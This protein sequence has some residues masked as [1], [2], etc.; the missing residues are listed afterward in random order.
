MKINLLGGDDEARSS[1]ASS[2]RRLNLYSELTDPKQGEPGSLTH[3]P[4]PGLKL[5]AQS[6]NGEN[7]RGLYRASNGDLYAAAGFEI[8]Y[9]DPSWT[10]NPIG[11]MNQTPQ[12]NPVKMIDNGVSLIIC[13]GTATNG[14]AVNM[15]SRSGLKPLYD[16]NA[17]DAETDSST[18][19]LGSTFVDFS[20]GY[21]IANYIG[22]PTFYISNS[23]DT[24]FDPLQFSGKT[25]YPDD[26][27]GAIVQHRV[28]WLIGQLTTEVW[29][30][31]GGGS[32]SGNNFPFEIMPGVAID[33]GCAAPYSIAKGDT[34]I[35]WLGQNQN[36]QVQVLRGTGYAVQRISTH[37][38]ETIFSRYTVSD[39]IAYF[40]TQGGHSFY[41]MSFPTSDATWA[42]D[43][44]TGHWHQRACIDSDGK[45]HRHRA[46]MHAFAYGINVV[47]DW[48][49][50][51][52][53]AFDPKIFNDNGQPIKRVLGFPRQID[54][55]NDHRVV[56]KN[57]VAEVDVGAG[58]APDL[59]P[60]MTLKWSDDKGKTFGNGMLMSIG[61]IGR[62]N[63]F[64]KWNRLGL[65]RNRTF[66]LE[67]NTDSFIALQGGFVE[68]EKSRA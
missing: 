60:T 3:Y 23:E 5:L 27:V 17:S 36:G 14:Y 48:A 42:Y 18:G 61:A 50:N 49:S 1:L 32:I 52:I 54:S 51:A 33:W 31:S 64:V 10:F 29:Y 68:I 6:P 45:E 58:F 12:R 25:A 56:F 24:I 65:A 44:A 40:Y 16:P 62:Y 34:S 15:A 47:N 37:A 21:L 38:M 30:N 67:W 22:T 35:F 20:D 7:V 13:D 9:V 63:T 28:L 55:E 19:W 39:C 8:Y 59:K 53:Y 4:T 43:L 41:V 26:L 57:F 46:D 2:Q 66:Q 11:A